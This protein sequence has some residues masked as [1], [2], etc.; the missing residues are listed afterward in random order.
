MIQHLFKLIWKRRKSNFLIMLEIFV[1]FIILFAVA[2][3]STY[4]V[5]NYNQPSGINI[6]NVWTVYVN[7]NSLSDSLNRQ[8]GEL[9]EQKL[10]TFK[11]IKAY[12]FGH[13]TFPYGNSHSQGDV[14]AKGK[15]SVNCSFVSI[16]ENA[17]SVLGLELAQGEW[18]KNTDTVGRVTPVVITQYMKEKIFGDENPIGQFLGT[19]N[20]QKVVGVLANFKQFSDF[21]ELSGTLISPFRD[22][23][24]SFMARVDPSVSAE[25]EAQFAKSLRQINKDWN[26][27]ILHTSDMKADKNSMY[28]IPLT[29]VFI[30]CGFL[31]VNVVLGLFGVLF[32]N[33]A[34]RR[35]EIGVRRAMGATQSHILSH[36]IGEMLVLATFAIGLGLFFAIQFP[37]LNVFDI[38]NSTYLLGIL[39]AVVVIYSLVIICA[40]LPSRQASTL[41]PAIALHEE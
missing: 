41:H 12:T 5:R 34:R 25:F 29:I 22:A 15:P 33:I 40:W 8:N 36:F 9:L 26:I 24:T 37:L 13:E 32:Q 17:P 35:N 1:A 2:S 38:E 16:D 6:D 23:K 3:L 31:I 27:E 21:D 28:T 39:V 14:G 19:E 30:V 20:R 4:L 7:Y 11:E 10:K 18:F